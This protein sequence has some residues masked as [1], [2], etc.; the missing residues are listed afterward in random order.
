MLFH[1]LAHFKRKKKIFTTYLT[2]KI[3][4]FFPL[5]GYKPYKIGI[6][7]L[8]RSFT[9]TIIN[10]WGNKIQGAYDISRLYE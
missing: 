9:K 5:S 8:D 4:V 1:V 7:E 3:C 6:N 10:F 2:K